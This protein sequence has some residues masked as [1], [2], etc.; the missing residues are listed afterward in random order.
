MF[1][2]KSSPRSNSSRSAV[3][4]HPKT[5]KDPYKVPGFENY[6]K[7]C[8]V[9]KVADKYLKKYGSTH[10]ILKD[11]NWVKEDPDL[12]AAAVLDW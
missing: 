1:R 9:G 11:P 12:V 4:T 6:G 5:D 8:F 3:P 7:H 2:N 10:S